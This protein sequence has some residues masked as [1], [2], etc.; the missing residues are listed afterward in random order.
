MENILHSYLSKLYEIR[1]SDVGNDGIYL[2]TDN[3]RI[4]Y[5][6]YWFRSPPYSWGKLIKELVVI[7]SLDEVTLEK[8]VDKWSLNQ[9]ISVNLTFYKKEPID[10][11]PIAKRIA[12][13]TMG[14]NLVSVQPMNQPNVKLIY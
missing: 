4:R 12:S 11:L 7:F 8:I 14:M 5:D 2:I 3:N 10:I 13:Q 9:K 1:T 6:K